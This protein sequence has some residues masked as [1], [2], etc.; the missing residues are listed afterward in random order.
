MSSADIL[1]VRS[2]QSSS[3][4][5]PALRFTLTGMVVPKGYPLEEHHVVTSDG[6]TLRTFRMAH[7]R[8][9]N[10]SWQTNHSR[11]P[12]LLLHGVSLSS[13]CWV[14]ND[15][16]ESLAF[17]LADAGKD[18]TTCVYC[19]CLFTHSMFRCMLVTCI[20]VRLFSHSMCMFVRSVLLL[21]MYA[22]KALK[23]SGSGQRSSWSSHMHTTH[24][25]LLLVMYLGTRQPV[26]RG[27]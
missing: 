2:Q 7:G 6:Y 25:S 17:I 24:H 23:R 27:L 26:Q 14:V 18:C 16:S 4:L 5:V 15:A 9:T 1:Q 12:V 21:Y 20:C 19:V 11:P 22:H 10:K 13:T 3:C 8:D